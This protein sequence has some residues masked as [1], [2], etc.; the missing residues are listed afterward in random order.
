MEGAEDEFTT[1]T[2]Y[3]IFP[4]KYVVKVQD[5]NG[6]LFTSDLVEIS[7]LTGKLF[8]SPSKYWL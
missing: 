4:G 1:E 2:H 8:F 6:C 5:A 3:S 7:T